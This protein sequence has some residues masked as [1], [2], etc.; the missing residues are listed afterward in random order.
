MARKGATSAATSRQVRRVRS[1]RKQAKATSR[2]VARQV[3]STADAAR[4]LVAS[5]LREEATRR[6]SAAGEQ[7]AVYARA[8]RRTSDQLEGEGQQRPAE[9][10]RQAADRLED[11]QLYL[12]DKDPAT[13]LSD[14]EDLARRNPWVLGLAGAFVGMAASRFLKASGRSSARR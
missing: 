9:M 3:G 8:L 14:L 13:L 6:V 1:A 5:G 2:E 12:R 10:V 11:F 4:E 7:V